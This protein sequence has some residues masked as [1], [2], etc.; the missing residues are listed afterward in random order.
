[1]VGFFSTAEALIEEEARIIYEVDNDGRPPKRCGIP[2]PK[3][4]EQDKLSLFLDKLHDTNEQQYPEITSF[5]V[6]RSVY[7]AFWGKSARIVNHGTAHERF[8]E[9]EILERETEEEMRDFVEQQQL[10]QPTE[11]ERRRQKQAEQERERQRQAEEEQLARL[12]EERR[13]KEKLLA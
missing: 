11:Q 2:K 13:A 4:H 3:D 12:V 1:M 10:A 6:R 9:Q 5:F 8:P 7:F